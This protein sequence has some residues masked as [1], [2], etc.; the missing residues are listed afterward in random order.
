[1][2][3]PLNAGQWRQELRREAA[4]SARWQAVADAAD[5]VTRAAGAE[6]AG[7]AALRLARELLDAP[8][9]AVLAL[10]GSRSLV[11]ASHG[12]A[13]PPGASVATDGMALSWRLAARAGEAAELCVP[14][15]ALG[16]TLGTLCLGWNARM[17]PAPGDVQAIATIAA[18]LA[19]AVAEP[20]RAPRRRKPAPP[21]RLG[22]LSARER[23]VLALLPRGLT[24]A[25][26]GAEL[27][28]S[29]GTA[30]VHVER[31]LQKLQLSDRTQAAV[32]AVQAGMAL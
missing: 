25:G 12:D 6:Q 8:H 2:Q 11:L 27:G 14:I 32:Y 5:A 26:L 22:A 20:A 29:T 19:P 1:M 4:D 21:D 9:A 3:A 13:L 23:Q 18:L 16:A 17:A 24:N 31:I 7:A 10:R 15:A 28:I 30:K